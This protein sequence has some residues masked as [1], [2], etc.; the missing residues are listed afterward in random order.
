MWFKNA[1][2]VRLPDGFEFSDN[3][4]QNQFLEFHLKPPGPF[5]KDSSGWVSPFGLDS[6]VCF[7]R[8]GNYLLIALGIEQKV[9][10]DAAIKHQVSTQVR[11]REAAGEIL[12]SDDKLLI[13]EKI[14]ADYLPTALTKLKVINA[15][16]DLRLNILVIDTPSFNMVSAFVNLLR[17]T[18][19]GHTEYPM[20]F[21]PFKSG[22][23]V[24]PMTQWVHVGD[25]GINRLE[26]ANN[27]V[28]G[29]PEGTGGVLRGKNIDVES[30]E[31]NGHI[32]KGYLVN[33]LGL[34]F[35][36]VV[37][38]TFSKDYVLKSISFD[39]SITDSILSNGYESE[40]DRVDAIFDVVTQYL[41]E[42][43]EQ[44]LINVSFQ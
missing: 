26:I 30:D 19:K 28:L 33:E 37:S 1:S 38:F 29:K 14:I 20:R 13:K 3:V 17:E 10:P 11:S 18:F 40:N 16:I 42:L 44:L 7:H 12:S 36:G 23:T 6:D 32:D 5:D 34:L 21:V 4:I 31:I 9:I 41:G 35:G 8:I 43:I 25:T 24:Q 2:I 22:N 27:V 15:F 39:K